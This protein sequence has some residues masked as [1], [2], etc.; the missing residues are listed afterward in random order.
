MTEISVETVRGLVASQAPQ[1]AHH[2]FTPVASGGTDNTIVRLGDK[3]CVRLPKRPEAVPQIDKERI[4]L[5]R[6][7]ALPLKTPMPVFNGTPD[8]AFEHPWGIYEWIEG[9]ALSQTHVTDWPAAAKA[10]SGFLLSLQRQD[11]LGAPRSGAQNHY[12]GVALIERDTLTRNAIKGLADLYPAARLSYVWEQA[13]QATPHTGEPTWL[14]GDL[15]GGNILVADGKITAIIDFG[16]A[17]VG[18]PACD[19]MVAWSVLPKSVRTEFHDQ[20]GCDVDSC[21]RGMGWAL[22]VSVIALDY[23][24]D[25]NPALSKISRQTIEAV[26]GPD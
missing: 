17:G 2:P 11:T 14:H 6:F 16:L 23:Y 1:F 15:Q 5:P 4:W 25:R 3:L 12:R 9:T 13:L 7:K 20:M 22:S 18:D 8:A 10:M 21:L 24:R 26:L 19:L